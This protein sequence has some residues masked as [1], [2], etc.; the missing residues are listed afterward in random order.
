MT[1]TRTSAVRRFEPELRAVRRR[2]DA[3]GGSGGSRSSAWTRSA[4]R[5]STPRQGVVG[6]AG[7][8]H[9]LPPHPR[10][11]MLRIAS[12]ATEK[13]ANLGRSAFEPQDEVA[14]LDPMRRA[15]ADARAR[16]RPNSEKLFAEAARVI[17][18]GVNSPVRSWRAVGGHPV[19]IQRG[20]GAH[21]IDVDG[22]DVR[23]LRRVLGSA[24]PRSRAPGVV[25]RRSTRAR[26]SGHELRR[27]DGR[28]RSSWRDCWSMRS[29][30]S[31]GAPGQ[32]R[33]RGDD[34]RAPAGA[35]G[36]RSRPRSSSSPAA[37]TGTSTRSWCAPG[38]EPSRSACPTAPG[39]R[40]RSPS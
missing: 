33:H 5:S 22:N 29:R 26:A 24:H 2:A 18:G 38:R 19:F 14:R 17:P 21:V 28:S 11:R 8:A 40:P 36:D 16:C 10:D 13:G 23:R 30:R 35:R 6:E 32:L 25:A 3:A 37:T 15:G 9:A 39:C 7:H 12:A 4:T 34:E 20:R 1:P 27:T 31:S